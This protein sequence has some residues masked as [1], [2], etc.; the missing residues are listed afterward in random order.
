VQDLITNFLKISKYMMKNQY[1]PNC[2]LKTK[3]LNLILKTIVEFD[4][5]IK[6]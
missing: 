2:Y 5:K 4:S 3:I 1:I 6:I